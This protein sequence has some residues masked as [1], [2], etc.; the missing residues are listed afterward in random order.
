[1]DRLGQTRV[2]RAA[3][4]GHV[5][6]L[7][8]LVIAAHERAPTGVLALCALCGGATF[9]Q[10]PAAMRSLWGALVEDPGQR[11]TAYVVRDQRG[12]CMTSSPT[13][14]CSG[15]RKAPGTRPTVTNPTC[16]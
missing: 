9:P 6:A 10:V 16:S 13:S 2:L 8:A 4:A 12:R 5:P 14:P 3:A 11:E 1:M 7:A 15:W